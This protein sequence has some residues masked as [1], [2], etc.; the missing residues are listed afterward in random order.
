MKKFF[1]IAVA[2]CVALA[3]CTKN[4][5]AP[6]DPQ[7]ITYQAVIGPSS[8]ALL[9][10]TAYP[11]GQTFGAIAY[12]SADP[13][14]PYINAAEVS[15]NTTG[16]YWSTATPYYWPVNA[17]LTFYSY[18]PFKYSE[19]G[20]AAISVAST[21]TGISIDNYD[22]AAHQ[23]TDLM[24]AD[25]Q[26]DLTAN[27]HQIAGWVKGVNTQF[28][29]KL[30]QVVGINFKTV[31]TQDPSQVKDYA[32]GHDGTTGNEYEAGDQQYVINSVTIKNVY[33]TGD[34]EYDATSDPVVETWTPKGSV[35][36]ST[37]WISASKNL[38]A[39]TLPTVREGAAN[40][41]LLVLPQEFTTEDA[42]ICVNYSIHTYINDSD[43][44]TE[45]IEANIPLKEVHTSS[46][47]DMNKKITYEIK[48]SKQRIYWA[49][50]IVD[51]GTEN[52]STTI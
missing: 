26:R 38:V 48:M 20:G 47:W 3:S 15:Y 18:S 23:E 24:V 37:S 10:G 50:S 16:K 33:F 11:T 21:A 7:E 36:A 13:S 46:K 22:V 12:S 44:S 4:E 5:V 51:W 27:N 40:N 45:T 17:S 1:L 49:P 32:N 14:T 31:N 25:V 34:Y 30:S 42:V 29:H 35:T 2:A 19:L 9:T 52:P 6:T 39:G 41:Y 28:R 8:K 43:F